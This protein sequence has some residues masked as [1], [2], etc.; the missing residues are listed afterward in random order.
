M[1]R[2]ECARL[3][4]LI[5]STWPSG[6]K[7]HVWT[8]TLG[9]LEY[10][11]A[12]TAYLKLRDEAERP[13]PVARFVAVYRAERTALKAIDEH[14]D[15]CQLCDGTGWIDVTDDRRHAFHCHEP[16][17][18]HCHAVDTCLCTIGQAMRPVHAAILEHNRR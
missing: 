11:I 5:V 10:D 7:G 15:I 1:T 12:R 14:I 17:T 18:C 8:D 13:P 3:V 2:D 6:V 9:D 4:N 16:D